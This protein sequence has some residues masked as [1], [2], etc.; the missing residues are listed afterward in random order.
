M[1]FYQHI[2]ERFR[3]LHSVWRVIGAVG[4]VLIGL[5]TQEVRS[6][7]MD[8]RSDDSVMVRQSFVVAADP[9]TRPAD[10][11]S[12]W[13]GSTLARPLFSSDRRPAPDATVRVAGAP[14]PLPR[15]TGVVISP[16]GAFAIFA[17]IDGGRP[18]VVGKGDL[19]GGAVVEGI[20]AGQVT[21]GG[22]DGVVLL[23][24][25][26]G[27]DAVQVSAL[28]AAPPPLPGYQQR[29]DVHQTAF[30]KA[31]AAAAPRRSDR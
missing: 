25:I 22:R 12:Q 7:A 21:L 4:V 16:A 26:F 2:R 20:L 1:Y 28:D 10:N 29:R 3:N 14:G 30:W 9:A 6:G 31:V 5:I 8:S 19:I 17:G 24:P 27:E 15:L 23:R 18:S 13:L 11:V